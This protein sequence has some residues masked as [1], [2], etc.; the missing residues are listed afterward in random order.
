MVESE[1]FVS[2]RKKPA[3]RRAPRKLFTAKGLVD[4]D[5]H[6]ADA[7]LQPTSVEEENDQPKSI[8][9][10][11]RS[12]F[13][14]EDSA[15]QDKLLHMTSCDD[16][17]DVRFIPNS[18]KALCEED[19][20][21]ESFPDNSLEDVLQM[22]CMDGL[23][24]SSVIDKSRTAMMR[25]EQEGNNN[26][27]TFAS[28]LSPK[29]NSV[30]QGKERFIYY[31]DVVESSFP[32]RLDCQ[33]PY[34]NITDQVAEAHLQSNIKGPLSE[35]V[36]PS[37]ERDLSWIYKSNHPFPGKEKMLGTKWSLPPFQRRQ[38]D[39]PTASVESPPSQIFIGEQPCFSDELIPVDDIPQPS[40]ACNLTKYHPK[41]LALR[42][43]YAF[44]KPMLSIDSDDSDATNDMSPEKRSSEKSESPKPSRS[45][46]K[47]NQ[48]FEFEERSC[49]SFD[50]ADPSID[51]L[52][53]RKMRTKSDLDTPCLHLEEKKTS[54]P[55]SYSKASGSHNGTTNTTDRSI[56]T[57]GS[58]M[59]V[60][61]ATDQAITSEKPKKAN[62]DKVPD[63]TFAEGLAADSDG[64][65]APVIESLGY[66]AGATSTYGRATKSISTTSSFDEECAVSS[67][68]PQDENNSPLCTFSRGIRNF[69]EKKHEKLSSAHTVKTSKECSPSQLCVGPYIQSQV[70]SGAEIRRKPFELMVGTNLPNSPKQNGD[71]EFFSP[72]GTPPTKRNS[73]KA[74][75][76]RRFKFEDSFDESEFFDTAMT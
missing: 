42:P 35:Y 23:F 8:F 5:T 72:K 55:D 51:V 11:H 10:T 3:E 38:V 56:I 32:G 24:F 16:I 75:D 28:M 31:R 74:G 33:L 20:S 9:S 52:D 4:V 39:F 18:V 59:D 12:S 70:S 6:K 64:K 1:T 60:S 61:V 21:R 50:E 47:K 17:A 45:D 36:G 76:I 7:S 37:E 67:S 22:G 68:M 66:Q 49:P 69:P 62:E 30:S 46:Q 71:D 63:E 57:G 13:L 53:N 2:R 14:V 43:N 48:I 44:E 29:L 65:A 25:L 34:Q 19:S 26:N 27:K 41:P 40:T 58:S 54:D 15:E 73:S